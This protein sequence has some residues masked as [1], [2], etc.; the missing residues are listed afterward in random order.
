MSSDGQLEV[1][2][3]SHYS[4]LLCSAT[5]FSVVDNE[6]WVAPVTGIILL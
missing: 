5:V 4:A 2:E 6:C 3:V 1:S